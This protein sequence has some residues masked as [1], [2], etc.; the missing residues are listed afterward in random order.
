[1][2][3][4]DWGTMDP[5][6]T[7]GIQLADKLNNFR[8]AINSAHKGSGRPS[9]VTAGMIWVKDSVSPWLIYMYDGSADVLI[10]KVGGSS[11]TPENGV[12]TGAVLYFPATTAPAGFIKANGGLLSRTT[13]ADLWAFANASGNLA[14]SDGAWQAGQFSP[15]DGSTT[16]RIPDGRGEGVRGWDDGRGIDTGR[17]IGTWQGDQNKAHSH[18]AITGYADTDHIHWASTSSDGG[19]Q[20]YYDRQ[21]D[22][23][24]GDPGLYGNYIGDGK[25]SSLTGAG[26]G[27]HNHTINVGG[28]SASHRHSI[29]SDGGSEVRVRNVAWLACIKY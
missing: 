1:M 5:A 28:M 6:A 23:H 13:Y 27:V 19:H 12:R 24:N 7:S 16:F 17:G 11:F 26:Q 8:N 20:H 25:T 2:S 21:A 29:A 10:G 3:Q 9:Y 4:F 15:G 14:A 18:G 22:G